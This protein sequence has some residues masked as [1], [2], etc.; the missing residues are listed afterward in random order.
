MEEASHPTKLI[1]HPVVPPRSPDAKRFKIVV[2]KPAAEAGVGRLDRLVMTR[3]RGF[4][5][6]EALTSRVALIS[7]LCHRPS[8]IGFAGGGRGNASPPPPSLNPSSPALT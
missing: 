7:F 5:L 2:D 1:L 6:I 8:P 3:L 4:I